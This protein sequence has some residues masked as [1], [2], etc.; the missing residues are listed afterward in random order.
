MYAE[1]ESYWGGWNDIDQFWCICW[2]HVTLIGIFWGSYGWN[3]VSRRSRDAGQRNFNHGFLWVG[4]RNQMAFEKSDE[5]R[6]FLLVLLSD[7]RSSFNTFLSNCIL[8]WLA[9]KLFTP[10]LIIFCL[11][12]AL[13]LFLH[14]RWQ[15]LGLCMLQNFEVKVLVKQK[16]CSPCHLRL[17]FFK[18]FDF[19]IFHQ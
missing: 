7:V 9:R 13:K 10:S 6:W 18:S 11:K 17:V 16:F 4:L 8:Y 19:A 14:F 5:I 2:V 15:L 3:R 1:A 12:I